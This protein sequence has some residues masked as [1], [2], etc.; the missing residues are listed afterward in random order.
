MGQPTRIASLDGARAMSITLVIIGHLSLVKTIPYAHEIHEV[1]MGNFGVRTFFVI[2]GFLITTLL[3]QE[4]ARTGAISLRGFFLRRFFRIFPA[5]YV[6]LAITTVMGIAGWTKIQLG[7][8][9]MVAAYLTNYTWVE[10]IWDHT[11]SL[12][13]E[14]QFYLLWPCVLVFAGFRF[15]FRA[16]LVVLIVSPLFRYAISHHYWPGDL[17]R[18]FECVADALATGCVLAVYRDKLMEFR[19]Y[20]TLVNSPMMLPF[21]LTTLLVTRFTIHETLVWEFLKVPTYN[22]LI[23]MLLDRYMRHPATHIGSLLNWKPIAYVGTISYSL[24][25]WQ[26][27]AMFNTFN[28]S[29]PAQVALSFAAALLSFYLVEQPFLKL[30]KRFEKKAPHAPSAAVQPAVVP[31]TGEP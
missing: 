15:G 22:I 18:S 3:L 29:A 10:W 21:A 26:Q 19:P 31:M 2:S 16:L 6:F 12:S 30:R 23:M 7:Q 25:L 4:K 17:A 20:R 28:L 27:A 13:V 11:W 1:D 5:Y 24:Y 9:P 14:E 8:L